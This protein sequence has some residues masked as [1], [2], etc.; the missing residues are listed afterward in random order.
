MKITVQWSET[1]QYC[2]EV[3]VP[4]HLDQDEVDAWIDMNF[5]LAVWEDASPALVRQND[6][7]TWSNP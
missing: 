7:V 5:F 3:E 4:D 6:D 2:E 1:H